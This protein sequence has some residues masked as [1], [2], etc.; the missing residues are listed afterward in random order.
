VAYKINPGV[1][2]ELI[3]TAV[4]TKYRNTEEIWLQSANGMLRNRLPRITI[5]YRPKDRRSRGRLRDFWMCET[6]T[7]Q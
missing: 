1:A 5:N 2:K 7:G 6:G 4:W 3:I